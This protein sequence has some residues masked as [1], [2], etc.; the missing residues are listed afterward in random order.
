MRWLGH[1]AESGQEEGMLQQVRGGAE[2]NVRE[3]G[4]T[5]SQMVQSGQQFGS[6]TIGATKRHMAESE[7][8]SSKGTSI[9]PDQD[10][11]TPPQ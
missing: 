1:H 4:H 11:D 10:D 3:L 2:Q 7:S 6:Q 8:R 5:G 9:G